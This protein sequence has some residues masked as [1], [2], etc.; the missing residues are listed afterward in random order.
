MTRAARLG[1]W[2][3]C[4]GIVGA[5][6]ALRLWAFG[7]V[8]FA[9]GADDARYVLVAQNLAHGYLPS[10]ETEWFGARAA[11]LWPVALLFRLFGAGDYAA[12]AWPLAT[13]LAAVVAA[14]LIGRELASTPLVGLLAAGLVAAA[15]LE[16]LMATRL[17]PDA[18]MPALVAFAVWAALRASR[19]S[20]RRILAWALMAGL[21]LGL[22][23]AARE[24]AV[25]M[26]PI[27]V[28]AGWRAGGRAIGVGVLG[29]LAVPTALAATWLI[30]GRSALTPLTATAG[31]SEVHGLWSRWSWDA[32]YSHYLLDGAL[33]PTRL[34]FLLA[35]LLLVAIAVV[36]RTRR[37]NA[38][39][40]GAWLAWAA[41]YLEIGTL[42]NLGKSPRFLTL[43]SIPA[44]LL[45]ALAAARMSPW[46][47]ATL[48]A[49]VAVIAVAA[50][51]PLPAAEARGH[52][53]VLLN[54]VVARMRSLPPA[55]VI[56]PNYVWWGKLNAYLSTS[57]LAVPRVRDP[58][59]L[60]SRERRGLRRL[61][62]LP[63][64][65]DYR[66]GYVVTGPLTKRRGWPTNWGTV[67]RQFTRQIPWSRLV[68]VARVEEATIYR[69]P[70]R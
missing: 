58:E 28:Y 68:V 31:A 19:A 62:P 40:V 22:G 63:Q 26:A 9:Y 44:A 25:I 12:V 66:G 47:G 34:V 33:R 56:T 51:R 29:A 53:V 3:G 7:G 8:S 65:A 59:F 52:D 70:A 55:P 10:G 6:L 17:R 64:I 20:D 23:W 15:P 27:V 14:Y 48:V 21:F 43:C 13:S 24:S 50:L 11:F 54:R 16:A 38:L 35:P 61:E 69:W 49:A 42:P 32:S 1:P 4:G 18:V 5:A 37:P 36:V 45:V 2:V 57:R 30:S 41:F 67:Q 60:D 39:F 46:L